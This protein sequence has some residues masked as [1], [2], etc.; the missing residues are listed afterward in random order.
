[1]Y[2][3]QSAHRKAIDQQDRSVRAHGDVVTDNMRM[4]SVFW[5]RIELEAL[6][7]RKRLR[8]LSHSE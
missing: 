4:Y 5:P 7:S 8:S 1:M 6:R 3:A 2:Q